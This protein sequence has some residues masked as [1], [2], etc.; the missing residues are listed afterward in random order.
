MTDAERKAMAERFEEVWGKKVWR[1]Y[2]TH[3]A[4]DVIPVGIALRFTASELARVSAPGQQAP[5]LAEAESLIRVGGPHGPVRLE[6]NERAAIADGL[7]V[8]LVG[9]MRDVFVDI[10]NQLDWTCLDLARAAIAHIGGEVAKLREELAEKTDARQAQMKRAYRAEIESGA[11]RAK[12]ARAEEKIAEQAARLVD[13]GNSI[14]VRRALL[15]RIADA[16]REVRPETATMGKNFPDLACETLR[17]QAATIE[18]LKAE[19]VGAGLPTQEDLADIIAEVWGS[20]GRSVEALALAY[21]ILDKLA[22][23]R[24]LV[25]QPETPAT[26]PECGHAEHTPA[27][28]GWCVAQSSDG[29]R[30]VQCLCD[31]TKDHPLSPALQAEVDSIPAEEVEEFAAACGPP[32][33]QPEVIEACPFPGLYWGDVRDVVAACKQDGRIFI[34]AQV[35]GLLRLLDEKRRSKRMQPGA[36][37]TRLETLHQCIVRVPR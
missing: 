37:M 8:A 14:D 9:R 17:E 24:P 34:P 6:A 16:V 29:P 21:Y 33:P 25:P 2:E 12:L 18:R 4:A 32:A 15:R 10:T 5:E 28:C 13:Y 26:C 22:P 3:L 30:D 36:V 19:P 1:M 11:L 31:C 27:K 7:D 35:E 23:I 20:H